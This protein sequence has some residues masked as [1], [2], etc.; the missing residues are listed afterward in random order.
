M[1]KRLIIVLLIILIGSSFATLWL[2]FHNQQIVDQHIHQAI[3]DY[4]VQDVA[5]TKKF[6]A[7]SI[8]LLAPIQGVKGDKGDTGK[9]GTSIQ[10]K[11]GQQGTPGVKGDKGDTVVIQATPQ[12]VTVKGDPGQNGKDGKSGKDGKNGRTPVFSVDQETGDIIWRYSDDTA[13]TVLLEH[14]KVTGTCTD[15]D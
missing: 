4:Q 1:S 8:Q 12:P 11:T 13:W 9:D 5:A 2:T 7:D 15:K 3:V 10:G 14:C 6:V